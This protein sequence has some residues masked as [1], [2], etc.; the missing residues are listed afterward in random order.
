[1]ESGWMR[2]YLDIMEP[3]RTTN[4]FGEEKVEYS[5]ARRIHAYMLAQRGNR[6]E[7]VQE[8]FPNYTA[9]FVIRSEH[10]IADNWRVRHYGGYLYTVT[11]IVPYGHARAYKTLQCE[12]VNE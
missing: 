6:S 4:S 9:Q 2:D 5:P 10:R 8:H 1:M 7:E 3:V 12:R 11:N